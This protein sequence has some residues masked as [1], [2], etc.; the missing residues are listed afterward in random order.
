MLTFY[1]FNM[2]LECTDYFFKYKSMKTERVWD[3]KNKEAIE[4]CHWFCL[5]P[6][7][8]FSW[9]KQKTSKPLVDKIHLNRQW[10]RDG[11]CLTEARFYYS[12]WFRW[13]KIVT[14][15]NPLVVCSPTHT[16]P[17]EICLHIP[18][19]GRWHKDVPTFSNFNLEK[20]YFNV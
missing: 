8:I 12:W 17:D 2:H 16:F 18:S 13:R 5:L 20:L 14:I 7:L 1:K 6:R 9:H 10:L 15:N 19:L 11:P 4:T 3:I